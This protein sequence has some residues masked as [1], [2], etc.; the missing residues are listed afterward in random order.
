LTEHLSH[1][2]RSHPDHSFGKS[3]KLCS[4]KRITQLFE[5]G[6]SVKTYPL[7]GLWAKDHDT[8]SDREFIQV[9]FSVPKRSFKR[10]HDRNKIKRLLRE[11]FR[12][13]KTTLESELKERNTK[14]DLFVIYQERTE[15]SFLQIQKKLNK[16]FEQLQNT[17]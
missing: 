8:S 11:A 12:L 9:A 16:L 14:I 15:L 6:D 10:A 3:Y 4:R 7:K 17:L 5:S 2:E 1:N 13:N